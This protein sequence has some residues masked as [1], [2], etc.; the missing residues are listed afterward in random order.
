[1]VV[2]SSNHLDTLSIHEVSR[3]YVWLRLMIQCIRKVFKL[4]FIKKIILLGYMK[5]MLFVLHKLNEDF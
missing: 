5:I 2:T 1:M 3:K 4:Q